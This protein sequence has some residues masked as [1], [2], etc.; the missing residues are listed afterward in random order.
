MTEDPH[1]RSMKALREMGGRRL[2]QGRK[3][4]RRRAG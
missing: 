4:L 2:H 3:I 1:D